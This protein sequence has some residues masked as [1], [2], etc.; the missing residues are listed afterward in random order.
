LGGMVGLLKLSHSFF[1]YAV[2]LFTRRQ[3]SVVP[4]LWWP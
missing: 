3:V 1:Y 2:D 4:R